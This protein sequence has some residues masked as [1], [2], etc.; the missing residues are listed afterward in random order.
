LFFQRDKQANEPTVSL[1]FAFK[2][3][4][5]KKFQMFFKKILDKPFG[6]NLSYHTILCQLTE[7]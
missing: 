2:R 6:F 4:T 5:G 1:F 3:V 7:K